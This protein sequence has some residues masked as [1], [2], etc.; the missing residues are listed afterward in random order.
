M[1]K[2]CDATKI[3]PDLRQKV[4]I[5][6]MHRIGEPLPTAMHVFDQ[7]FNQLPNQRT[8]S[9]L[10]EDDGI[11][12][13]ASYYLSYDESGDGEGDL[14]YTAKYSPKG[15]YVSYQD[16]RW[17]YKS[18]KVL[19]FI[20]HPVE[21][22]YTKHKA[23][24]IY[25]C[26]DI[27]RLQSDTDEPMN[28]LAD[29]VCSSGT[30]FSYRLTAEE[31]GWLDFVRR[32][33]QIADYIDAKIDNGVLVIED[34]EEMSKALDDDCMGAGKA[35]SLSDDTALQAIFFWFYQEQVDDSE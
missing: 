13:R 22:P 30:P 31:L 28:I 20:E 9:L 25:T 12:L 8:V 32:S 29:A 24:Y 35:V 1:V 14:I 26:S 3:T 2:L 6:F 16:L 23:K 4:L 7:S 10:V 21:H 19:D 17:T 34:V 11:D 18:R 15:D 33:Y 27:V 5:D